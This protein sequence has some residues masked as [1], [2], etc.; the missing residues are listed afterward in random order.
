MKTFAL[1]Y[2]FTINLQ[3]KSTTLLKLYPKAVISQEIIKKA[4]LH[5]FTLVNATALT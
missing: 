1:D 3:V 5:Y 4:T 2:N